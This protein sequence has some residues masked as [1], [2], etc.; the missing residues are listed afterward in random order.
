M[1]RTGRSG[2]GGDELEP[3]RGADDLGPVRQVQGA[4]LQQ[5]HQRGQHVRR[6]QV[7][8]LHKQPAAAGDGLQNRSAA[9]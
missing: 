8:V 3:G 2:D 7:Q 9:M 6:R 4:A 5:R 1:L